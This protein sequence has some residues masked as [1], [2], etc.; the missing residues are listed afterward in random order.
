MESVVYVT[1]N[2]R[3]MT[4]PITEHLLKLDNIH[5]SHDRTNTSKSAMETNISA[6]HDKMENSVTA[7][8]MENKK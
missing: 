6:C 5:A 3:S 8:K 2:V 4:E 1:N 7:N